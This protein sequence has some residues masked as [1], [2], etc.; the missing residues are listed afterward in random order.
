MFEQLGIDEN[1]K[2]IYPGPDEVHAITVNHA[3][4]LID[5]L[6]TGEVGLLEMSAAYAAIFNE[7]RLVVPY[8][9]DAVRAGTR[10][11]SVGHAAAQPVLDPDKAAMMAR[12]MAAVRFE[13]SSLA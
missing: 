9:V 7:G 8:G 2:P 11:T 12:M 13:T 6:G 5:L 10:A 1:G 4:K 3:Q